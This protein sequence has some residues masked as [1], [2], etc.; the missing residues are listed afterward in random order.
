MEREFTISENK[1][2]NLNKK[3]RRE[4]FLEKFNIT[5]PWKVFFKSPEPYHFKNKS[6]RKSQIRK[7]NQLYH[8][9]KIHTAMDAVN[10]MLHSGTTTAT[11]IHNIF[12]YAFFSVFL[13]ILLTK[14][15]DYYKFTGITEIIKEAKKYEK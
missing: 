12:R 13:F 3:T 9:T 14:I 2:N 1:Y 6:G 7:K 8:G 4:K 5:I 15:Y 10:R 11:N